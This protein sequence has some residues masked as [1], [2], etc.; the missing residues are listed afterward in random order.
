MLTY[1]LNAV[2]LYYLF[3]NDIS[4]TLIYFELIE[5]YNYSLVYHG[6]DENEVT[7]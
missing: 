5:L 7:K 2:R 3:I 4:Y 1:D 6:R